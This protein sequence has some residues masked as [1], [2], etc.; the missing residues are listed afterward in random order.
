[1][2]KIINFL[3]PGDIIEVTL[4]DSSIMNF[5]IYNSMLVHGNSG[6]LSFMLGDPEDNGKNLIYG[7]RYG[8][9]ISMR[10]SRLFLEEVC[11]ESTK[12][13][14][15]TKIVISSNNKNKKYYPCNDFCKCICSIRDICSGEEESC[16]YKDYNIPSQLL[17][18]DEIEFRFSADYVSDR[19]P[20]RRV[21]IVSKLFNMEN[22]YSGFCVRF[23]E[24]GSEFSNSLIGNV[25]LLNKNSIAIKHNPCKVCFSESCNNC[26]LKLFKNVE[27][28]WRK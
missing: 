12:E 7:N 23:G 8:Y 26:E 25:R 10:N 24:G 5:I 27:I 6:E 2:E 14:I 1:M 20:E 9:F 19:I 16:E 11:A 21:G 13:K 28:V 15:I 3:F 4:G 17:I 18:G 22:N